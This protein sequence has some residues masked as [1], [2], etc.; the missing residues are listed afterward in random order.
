VERDIVDDFGST[1]VSVDFLS[2]FRLR[3]IKDLS[4]AIT[5]LGVD[6]RCAGNISDKSKDENHVFLRE[7]IKAALI[8]MPFAKRDKRQCS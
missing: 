8:A 7:A 6:K 1:G 3:F 4:L 2:A 5:R